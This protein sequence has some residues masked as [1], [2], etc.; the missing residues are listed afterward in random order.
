MPIGPQGVARPPGPD[1]PVPG[2]VGGPVGGAADPGKTVMILVAL[3]VRMLPPL[4]MLVTVAVIGI[5]KAS[6]LSFK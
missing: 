2:N 1:A 6:S 3:V 4:V 5:R